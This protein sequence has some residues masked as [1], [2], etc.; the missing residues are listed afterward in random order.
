MPGA[1]MDLQLIENVSSMVEPNRP[2]FVALSRYL[3]LFLR[4]GVMIFPF[5]SHVRTEPTCRCDPD[6]GSY[7]ISLLVLHARC[8]GYRPTT[9]SLNFQHTIERDVCPVLHVV[10][11]SD[12]IYHV[13]F[14]QILQCPA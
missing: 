5:W 11:H 9:I 6:A 7:G 2:H 13:A 10:F 12:L 14:H 8:L 4:D 3:Q 1:R